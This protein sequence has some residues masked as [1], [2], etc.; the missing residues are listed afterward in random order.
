MTLHC[1]QPFPFSSS[2]QNPEELG[3][4][5]QFSCLLGSPPPPAA[6]D[7]FSIASGFP[8]IFRDVPHYNFLRRVFFV[9]HIFFL[10]CSP[11]VVFFAHTKV[12]PSV[13]FEPMNDH[14][15]SKTMSYVS[16]KI[17]FG[18]PDS[19]SLGASTP[20]STLSF[21]VFFPPGVFFPTTCEMPVKSRFVD[22]HLIGFCL[23]TP[24]WLRCFPPQLSSLFLLWFFYL[25][26]RDAFATRRQ[27]VSTLQIAALSVPVGLNFAL[28]L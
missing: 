26:I 10:L 28:S 20:N 24:Y 9:S 4:G 23:V 2:L 22:T 19:H 18:D 12:P 17:C 21:R 27:E 1:Y 14:M 11:L 5:S 6:N 8:G 16:Y 13:S 3:V 7:P 15:F 25:S